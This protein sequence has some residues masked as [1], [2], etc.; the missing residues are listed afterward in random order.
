M[1]FESELR[2]NFVLIF[3]YVTYVYFTNKEITINDVILAILI[4][5]IKYLLIQQFSHLMFY[6]VEEIQIAEE[7]TK[8]TQFVTKFCFNVEI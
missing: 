1:S 2:R 8:F 5:E 6:Y 4:V 7:L 3:R